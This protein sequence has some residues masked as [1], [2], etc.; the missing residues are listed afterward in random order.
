MVAMDNLAVPAIR[1]RSTSALIGL[2][3]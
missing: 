1:N 2:T 3:D